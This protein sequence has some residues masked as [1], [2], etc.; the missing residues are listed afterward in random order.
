MIRYKPIQL[1]ARPRPRPSPTCAANKMAAAMSSN[2]DPRE[3]QWDCKLEKH[4]LHISQ[5]QI[6]FV[7]LAKLRWNTFEII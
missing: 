5:I 7:T 1:A 4:I 6:Q 3:T 2:A